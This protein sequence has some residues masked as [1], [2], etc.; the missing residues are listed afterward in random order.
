MPL[1]PEPWSL[2]AVRHVAARPHGDGDGGGAMTAIQYPR[3]IVRRRLR[4][5]GLGQIDPS[6]D[7]FATDPFMNAVESWATS[8]AAGTTTTTT[9]TPINWTS[10]L[11][12]LI[13]TAGKTAQVSMTPLAALPAGSYYSAS[14]YGTVV[15]T[16]GAATSNVLASTLTSSLSSMMPIL[17]IGGGL[18]V[19]VMMLKK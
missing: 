4:L 6:T 16:G 15:S 2:R 11:G 13:S 8:P 9:S 19:V 5:R 14:P 10:I 12:N 3:V 18:L 17:L 7:P 1:V